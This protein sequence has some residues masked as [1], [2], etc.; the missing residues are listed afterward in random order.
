[1]KR[2]NKIIIFFLVASL[3]FSPF[4]AP[5][6]NAQ[7][8]D[9]VQNIKE[10]GLDPIAWMVSKTILQ[11]MTASTVNWI[12]KGF[13]GSPAFVTDPGAYFLNIGDQIAG[14]LIFNDPNL[15]FL[16][17][18]IQAKIRIALARSYV[19]NN[20]QDQKQ[21]QCTLTDAV[22]NMDDFLGDF[23]KGG[24]D[25][26]FEM[27]QKQQNN[28]IGAYLQAQNQMNMQIATRQ[29]IAQSQLNWGQGFMSY[30]ECDV[31]GGIDQNCRTVTPGSIIAGKLNGALGQGENALVT[32]DEINEL[33][34]A[35]LSQL[36]NQ[37]MGGVGGLLGASGGGGGGAAG[38]SLTNQLLHSTAN[39]TTDY[40]GNTQQNPAT[41]SAPSV[42]AGLAPSGLY[43]PTGWMDSV[44]CDNVSGWTCDA[45]DYGKPIEVH[46]YDGSAG[47]GGVIIGTTL[48]N[49]PAE[50]AVASLCGN[51]A[52]HRFGFAT[53]ASVKDGNVHTIYAYAINTPSGNNPVLQGS[54]KSLTCQAQ[55][56]N[57]PAVNQP[58]VQN[59][60]NANGISVQLIGNNPDTVK[61]SNLFQF[62]A[63]PGV[64][65]LDNSNNVIQNPT[66]EIIAVDL[67]NNS[68]VNSIQLN[69]PNQY[70]IIY[71][72]TP[73]QG[74][75]EATATR[76]V[77]VEP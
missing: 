16:C 17:G 46:F 24:W 49:V 29:G 37:V 69:S 9:I 58:V 2:I 35:L 51:N 13:K 31:I 55:A 8:I 65:V 38:P 47:A 6:A 66:I 10:F 1:M 57:Q 73:N 14:N 19:G 3:T 43:E 26:F 60:P 52:N 59:Q 76:R 39:G 33:V 41:P 71:N 22:G 70:N 5:R 12:N 45:D 40:F 67:S 61:M 21:W 15:N 48:A 64:I 72:Y 28:P 77:V 42:P 44:N 11:R 68:V 75:I 18:P 25:K 54:P 20:M 63:D 36:T 27:T 53:P 32:A 34:G 50:P 7:Y 23:N 30:E 56:I 4:L 74:V 62:Y